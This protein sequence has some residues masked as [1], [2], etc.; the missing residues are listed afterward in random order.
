MLISIYSIRVYHPCR[1][2]DEI[3]GITLNIK[4]RDNVIQI[5]NR[6]AIA[7]REKVEAKIRELLSSPKDEKTLFYKPCKF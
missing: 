3:N 2:G 5:W 6:S 4:H 1:E 7:P